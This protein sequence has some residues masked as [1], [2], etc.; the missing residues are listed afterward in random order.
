MLTL[1][2]PCLNCGD[3]KGTELEMGYRG[4]SLIKCDSC[5]L[6]YWP[7]WSPVFD[8]SHDAHYGEFTD[9]YVPNPITAKGLDD[10][11]LTLGQEIP[12]RR[13]LDVGCGWGD[14]VDAANRAGWD[15]RGIDLSS[16]VISSCRARGVNCE[17][18]DF[19]DVS[20]DEKNYDLIIMSELIEHVPFPKKWFSHARTLLS[21]N[22]ILY[23]TTPNYSSLGRRVL[24]KDWN[25]IGEGHIGYYSPKL[26]CNIASDCGLEAVH[27][28]AR[29]PS[30]GAIRKLLT[31][32]KT[33]DT[34]LTS[35]YDLNQKVRQ[36]SSK[37]KSLGVAKFLANKALNATGLGE[38]IVAK[39]RIR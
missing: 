21:E 38:S 29:N 25:V 26:L 5:D 4:L 18:F 36:L 17:L 10:L 22:G 37:H 35:Q 31:P 3:D 27:I 19:F 14:A 15:A 1:V 16:T 24:K 6:V 39:F 33:P 8:V 12:G 20:P 23:M 13:V 28:E 9:G 11:F 2:S 30:I 34:F 32:G 7:G